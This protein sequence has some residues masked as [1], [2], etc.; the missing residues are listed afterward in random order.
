MDSTEMVVKEYITACQIK[1]LFDFSGGRPGKG[2]TYIQINAVQ[3]KGHL[4]D[5]KYILINTH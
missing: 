2:L 5:S 4:F 3:K 1:R